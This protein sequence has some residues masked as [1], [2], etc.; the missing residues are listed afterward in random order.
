VNQDNEDQG[1]ARFC[2]QLEDLKGTMPL[3]VPDAAWT[4][5]ILKA[6]ERLPPYKS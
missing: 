1:F 3:Y 2:E 4:Q 6:I 5:R